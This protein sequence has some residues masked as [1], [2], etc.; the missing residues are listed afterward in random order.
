LKRNLN[1]LYAT[2]GEKNIYG[3]LGG[4]EVVQALT[5]WSCDLIEL[6]KLL[7]YRE[8]FR[9]SEASEETFFDIGAHIGLYSLFLAK[10]FERG[11][12]FE[13]NPNTYRLLTMNTA[14]IENLKIEPIAVSSKNS[15]ALLFGESSKSPRFRISENESTGGMPQYEE[16]LVNTCSLESLFEKYGVPNLIKID[17]EGHEKSALSGLGKLGNM[18]D[19]P[20]LVI[21]FLGPQRFELVTMLE[22][23]GYTKFVTSLKMY[24][25]RGHSRLR[26]LTLATKAL[27]QGKIKV[28]SKGLVDIKKLSEVDT[29]LLLVMR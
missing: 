11:V 17:V 12:A 10:R 18:E 29:E 9:K 21:E 20:D 4:L 15:T 2:L 19:L 16:Y 22:D 23:F 8:A 26:V 6:Q 5:S 1:I 27:W 3:N 7:E 13:P 25:S 24:R 14:K 28:L